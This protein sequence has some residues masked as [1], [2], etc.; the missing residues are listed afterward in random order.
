MEEAREEVDSAAAEAEVAWVVA[1][2]AEMVAVARVVEAK[3]AAGRGEVMEGVVMG[4]G[5]RGAAVTVRGWMA[6]G[7]VMA[8]EG[9][10]K[11]E[12]VM[13]LA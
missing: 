12:V 3:V 6:V 5:G 7:T 9:V 4:G 1:M 2:A 8:K 13:G 10:A 11:E